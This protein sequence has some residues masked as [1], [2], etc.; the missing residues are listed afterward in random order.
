MR[1]WKGSKG[2]NHALKEQIIAKD[3]LISRPLPR[4]PAPPRGPA[5]PRCW[6]LLR[7]HVTNRFWGKTR[8]PERKGV[9]WDALMLIFAPKSCKHSFYLLKGSLWAPYIP[10]LIID[11]KF[12]LVELGA[13]NRGGARGRGKGREMRLSLAII[14]SF[15]VWLPPFEPFQSRIQY[16]YNEPVKIKW[17]CSL[18]KYIKINNNFDCNAPITL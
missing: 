4:P 14:C 7:N 18:F 9:S 1:L 12:H 15:N 11:S 13:Q 10:N 5:P 16:F 2:G 3:S 6:Y 17:I 8:L